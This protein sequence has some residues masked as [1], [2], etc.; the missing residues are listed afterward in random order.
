[1]SDTTEIQ[2]ITEDS[3][4]HLATLRLCNTD[5]EILGVSKMTDKDG[6]PLFGFYTSYPKPT[7]CVA[8]EVAHADMS[9]FRS[10]LIHELIHGVSEI[11]GLGLSE[12]DVRVIENSIMGF[13]RDNEDDARFL[14]FGDKKVAKGK[15]KAVVRKAR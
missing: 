10:A 14:F 4:E 7:V 11:N 9:Q 13:C 15:R 1:M 2:G 3:C 6:D 8:T 5:V 12:K